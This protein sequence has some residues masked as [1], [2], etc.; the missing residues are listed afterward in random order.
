MKHADLSR[1]QRE[2]RQE[3]WSRLLEDY[4]SSEVEDY[5][6]P[7]DRGVPCDKCHYDWDLQLKYVKRLHELGE[8][9]L[10]DEVEKYGEYL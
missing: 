10:D 4:C 1:E 2:V 7:C 3:V 6:K 5:G 8:Q 9:L